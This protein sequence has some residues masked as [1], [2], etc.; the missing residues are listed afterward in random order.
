MQSIFS[1]YPIESASKHDAVIYIK[2][3]K[4]LAESDGLHHSEEKFLKDFIA[5]R[6][7][8]SD[9][10][11]LACEAPI[12]SIDGLNLTDAHR[13][14]FGPY[15]IRDLYLIALV[16]DGIS[17]SEQAAIS[18]VANK[19]GIG[20]EACLKIRSATECQLDALKLWG[21]CVA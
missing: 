20:Q 10:W 15:L 21:Q 3:L 6:D 4:F 12:S 17:D 13:L 16:H 8:P 18:S 14:I 19:L 1:T 5:R 7:W 9:V 11:T 2:C